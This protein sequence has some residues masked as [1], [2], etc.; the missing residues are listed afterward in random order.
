MIQMAKT[1]GCISEISVKNIL[2]Q[3]FNASTDIRY[4]G[5]ISKGYRNRGYIE[6]LIGADD[7]YALTTEALPKSFGSLQ[8]L[9][10]YE[11]FICG[12]FDPK[13]IKLII[14]YFKKE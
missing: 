7:L 3:G 6:F 12:S 10:E 5:Q 9:E 13:D 2:I 8:L 14:K 4:I 1:K 11:G